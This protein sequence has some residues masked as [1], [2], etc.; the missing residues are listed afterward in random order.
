MLPFIAIYT[1]TR[2][3]Y[4][5]KKKQIKSKFNQ[6]QAAEQQKL[7]IQIAVAFKEEE[8]LYRFCEFKQLHPS[9]RGTC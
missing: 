6:R 5:K 9:I 7:T 3:Q 1:N 8:E 2:T 4:L